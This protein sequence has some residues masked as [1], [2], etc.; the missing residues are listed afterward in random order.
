M[1]D[2][3]VSY[4]CLAVIQLHVQYRER[5]PL[6]VHFITAEYFKA[7]VAVDIGCTGILLVH[8]DV[9]GLVQIDG[10]QDEPLPYPP[11]YMVCRNK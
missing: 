11:A 7:K 4:P 6:P 8:I 9:F 1:R 3:A 2:S 10:R 5:I